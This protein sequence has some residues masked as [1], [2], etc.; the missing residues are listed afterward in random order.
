MAHPTKEW[1]IVPGTKADAF[2]FDTVVKRSAKTKHETTASM[3]Q[4]EA[5][6]E[7]APQPIQGMMPG[8][9]QEWRVARALDRL[10]LEYEYQKGIGGGRRVR[11]G[12]VIDFWVF[13]APY[14]TPVF[15]QG[16]YWHN[17]QTEMEDILKQERVQ[18]IYKGQVMPNLVLKEEDLSSME[19]AYRVVRRRL[20]G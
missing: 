10:K 13:T 20:I 14:P 19:A 17:R 15:I 5:E 12:Q 18:R 1:W 6:K 8:S 3:Y 9:V 7:E 11:G 16:T 2:Q 4:P